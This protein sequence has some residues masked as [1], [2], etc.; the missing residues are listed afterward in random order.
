MH[1]LAFTVGENLHLDEADADYGV[2]DEAR[3]ITEGAVRPAYRGL[4]GLAQQC[5]V[6]DATHAAPTAAGDGLLE[7]G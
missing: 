7:R 5:R 3:G 2:P 4:D 6:V 1:H